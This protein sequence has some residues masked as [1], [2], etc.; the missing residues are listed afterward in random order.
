MKTSRRQLLQW[1]GMAAGASWSSAAAAM[2]AGA[3]PPSPGSTRGSSPS[4]GSALESTGGS[5]RDLTR[6]SPGD[7][8]KEHA[9]DL[10][11]GGRA[12]ACIFLFL[13]GGPSH[14]DLF[15]RR[16][17]A[18]AEFR[19]PFDS[20]STAVP[21]LQIC[22]HL[23]GMARVMDRV[24]QVRSLRHTETVHDPAVY[25]LL[26]GYKHV[27]SAGGLK[28]EST[29][30]PHWG[31][32]LAMADTRPGA[33]PKF[34]QTPGRMKMEARILPGQNAGILP[35]AFDPLEVE[36]T[37]GG[38][39]MPPDFARFAAEPP[40]RLAERLRL[41]ADFNYEAASFPELA[42]VERLERFRE[43]AAALANS[44]VARGAFDL[45]REPARVR[46]R[47]GRH[48]H[49]QSVLLARRL[50][51]AGARLVTVYWGSE[52]QDWAD[53]KGPRPANNPWDTHRNHFPLC[54][55]SLLPRADQAYSALIEDLTD[56][57]L[58]GETLVVWTGEFG[59]TPRISRP[60]A[61]RDHWPHAF[62]ALLAGAGVRGGGVYGRTDRWAAEVEERPV[63]PADLM[64]TLFA[65]LGVPPRQSLAGRLGERHRL[66][67]GR[68]IT[69]WFGS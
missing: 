53:G 10:A 9:A 63:A 22:E 57:G 19:G 8:T 21:G 6:S 26:T 52:P 67:E 31:A 65:S 69:E 30:R 5:N 15:D 45:Q 32:A 35:A 16:P 36:V 38:D 18:P 27:S 42:S 54:R 29:D 7:S 11:D 20:I 41:L 59:R 39:V 47:Y 4:P 14:I 61:S 13:D 66:S 33:L 24:L 17:D 3:M 2:V 68:V 34:I 60:W 25:Q 62:T 49:G 55:D 50:V 44:P 43:Q 48:R 12:K 46:E 56:R 23:P 37:A 58:L 28:V 51:E 64:A 40:A 1:T